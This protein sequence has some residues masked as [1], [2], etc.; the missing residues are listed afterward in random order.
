[1]DSPTP[2]RMRCRDSHGPPSPTPSLQ[3]RNHALSHL[4]D[5]PRCLYFKGGR[6]GGTAH[7]MHHV[8]PTHAQL[9][10]TFYANRHPFYIT[11]TYV[12]IGTLLMTH[13]QLVFYILASCACVPAVVRVLSVVTLTP[14]FP[15]NKISLSAF[16]VA[17][18]TCL[19]NRQIANNL[20]AAILSA[21]RCTT[22]IT[23]TSYTVT[24]NIIRCRVISTPYKI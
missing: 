22:T 16:G 19:L 3:S 7:H 8:E 4:T 15:L 18:S 5:P 24:L 13:A 10:I 2:S 21:S 6:C 1:M 14:L 17:G 9:T 11:H 23:N 12:S 20:V